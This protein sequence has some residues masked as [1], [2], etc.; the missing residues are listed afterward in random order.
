MSLGTFFTIS[1]C[2]LRRPSSVIHNVILRSRYFVERLR[3]SAIG[4]GIVLNIGANEAHKLMR[5]HDT[6]KWDELELINF[7]PKQFGDYDID[8]KISYCGVCGSDV[9]SATG[10]WGAPLLVCFCGSSWRPSM[11]YLNTFSTQPL[12]VGH[13]ITG[14]V[15][16]VGPKVTEF[17]VGDRAGVGAQVSSCFDC[18]PCNTDNEN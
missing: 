14:E 18:V 4:Y 17:K 5:V 12:I 16:R 7:T 10:G 15:V 11:K 9:H 3:V 1:S 13:E 8:I 6:N 2:F